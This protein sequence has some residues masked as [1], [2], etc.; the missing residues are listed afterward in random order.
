MPVL[1]HRGYH[2]TVP[3]NTYE[4]L[5]S[6][7]VHA[8]EQRIKDAQGLVPMLCLRVL[9]VFVKYLEHFS[10]TNHQGGDNLGDDFLSADGVPHIHH[11]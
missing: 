4:A 11:G 2:V 6:A 9:Q 3:E 7:L 10:Q 8:S 1:S 5:E